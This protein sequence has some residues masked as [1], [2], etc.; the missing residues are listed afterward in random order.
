[1]LVGWI[2]YGFVVIKVCTWLR[3]F[4]PLIFVLLGFYIVGFLIVGNLASGF[5]CPR[6]GAGFCTFGP[7]GIG[8]NSFAR[9][10]GNCGL[11]KWACSQDLSGAAPARNAAEGPR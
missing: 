4:S 7:W 6:C 1:M 9:K 10:C 5:R 8:H 3:I 11:R 2:P